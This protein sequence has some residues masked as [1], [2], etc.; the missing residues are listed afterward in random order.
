[1]RTESYRSDALL[2]LLRVRKIAT[3]EE[4][5][6]ALGTAVDMTVF[7][8]LKAL[9]YRTSYSHRGMYYALEEVLDFDSRGLWVLGDVRFS[10]H[11]T[12][13][14]TVCA[15]VGEADAGLFCGELADALGVGVKE[16]LLKLVRQERVSRESLS[17]GY[18]Y[19]SAMPSVRRRQLMARRLSA[20]AAAPGFADG[21]SVSDEIKAAIVLFASMLDE[22]QRRLYAGLESLKLGHGGDRRLAELT[23]MDVHTV[24]RGRRELLGGDVDPGRVRTAGGGRKRVEKKLRK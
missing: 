6:Q 14:E 4:L 24:A 8:K 15:F 19:C 3:L 12:L 17:G 23:G 22:K 5:K 21:E 16:A 10:K 20:S 1:M 18:L 13:L 11:G 2:E 7:R 9:G